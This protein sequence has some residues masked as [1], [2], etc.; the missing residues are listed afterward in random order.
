MKKQEEMKTQSHYY[1]YI[2]RVF[3]VQGYVTGLISIPVI[4]VITW[5][6][7]KKGILQR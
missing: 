3:L 2:F 6:Y 4:L 1:W 7:K 5:Y